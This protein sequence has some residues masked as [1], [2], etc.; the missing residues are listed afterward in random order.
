MRKTWSVSSAAHSSRGRGDRME[1]DAYD[2]IGELMELD[3]WF[4]WSRRITTLQLMLTPPKRRIWPYI[5]L[6][7]CGLLGLA[8]I[9]V[10]SYLLFIY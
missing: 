8:A 7:L 4:G 6:P 2:P 10:A 9:G 1:S 3:M 5:V